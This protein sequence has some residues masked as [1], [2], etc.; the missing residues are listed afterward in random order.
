[1]GLLACS[2]GGGGAEV[3]R[4]TP[5]EVRACPCLTG[6]TG[7]QACASDGRSYTLC[8]C[9]SP[10]AAPEP[11]V[12]A[13][14]GPVVD[15]APEP[16]VDSAPAPASDAALAE[17]APVRL[18]VPPLLGRPTASGVT[19]NVV[20]AEAVDLQVEV[21]SD[22]APG[23]L[24][25][26]QGSAAAD[27]PTTLTVEGLAP[28]TAYRYRVLGRALG[29]AAWRPAAE[30]AFHTQRR[31]GSGFVFTVQADSHLD[32]K[33][34][35]ELYHRALQNVAE[36]GADFHIDLG[37]TF[38]TEKH[39]APFTAEVMTAVDEPAVSARYLGE[40][41]HF[42]LMSPRVPLFLVNGNHE[43]E[44]GWRRVDGSEGQPEWAVRARRLYYLNPTPD[45]FYTG[46]PMD[47][48]DVGP[49]DA[50]YAWTWGD[51][52]F[53]VLDPFWYTT[54]RPRD[55]WA[56]TLGED[57][58]RWLARTLDASDARWKFV[59]AHHLVG[60]VNSSNRGG[61]EGAR[62]YEWGGLDDAGQYA[63]DT[64]RPGWEAPIHDLLVASGVS[65][66]FH[67]HDHLY[68]A[69]VLDGVVYQA[70]PQ[71]SS[72]NERNVA[73]LA[74]EGGYVE[75]VIRPSSG[76]LRVSVSAARVLVDYVRARTGVDAAR[77]GEIDHSYAIEG[78]ER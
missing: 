58:Y 66:F 10:D 54:S 57:Q 67:G 27:A 78:R 1:M 5:G 56:W 11:E 77:N 75:G 38:M 50:Y 46:A 3:A 70:V 48:P 35:L 15:S 16:M 24:S 62:G 36:S 32:D 18:T 26:A 2:E 42:G 65:A 17:G 31:P 9:E 33:S 69:Q 53:V 20:P 73:T 6:A 51:A 43:G 13:A 61:V 52:L 64:Q 55:L 60:G 4:C 25:Q 21:T 63:F 71:P 74:A 23:V 22:A 8:R 72:P 45:A 47:D 49:R 28:D 39:S 44:Q 37:D 12:D 59:F 29:Q 14:T 41:A 30:G 40:R 68:A 76:V 7:E 34:D 19:L